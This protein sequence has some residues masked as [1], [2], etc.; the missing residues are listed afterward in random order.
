MALDITFRISITRL[1]FSKGLQL[2]TY[3]FVHIWGI[4]MA[5]DIT[6]RISINRLRFSKGLKL[7]TYKFVHI[8]PRTLPLNWL[9]LL[10]TL[11]ERYL[12]FNILPPIIDLS[13]NK[14]K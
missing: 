1:R 12:G 8:W 3:K 4:F 6:F 7:D 9:T 5:L 2:D 11:K 13:K 14:I 10:D